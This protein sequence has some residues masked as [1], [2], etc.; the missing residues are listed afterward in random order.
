MTRINH[1]IS[2]IVTQTALGRAGKD[3]SNSLERLS[4][5]LRINR[6]ADDAAGLSVSE[7]LRTQVRGT[8][9]AMRNAADGNSLLRVAEGALNEVSEMTQRMRELAIQSD[10]D[11]LTSR[12]R[13]YLDQEFSQLKAEIT[14]ISKS[15]QFN[16]LT[17]LDGGPNS[18]GTTTGASILHIGAN[19][20]AGVDRLGITLDAV[21][22]TG[23]GL[24]SVGIAGGTPQ[25]AHANIN[26]AI[27]AL[28][29]AMR[30]V[31]NVRSKIG[32]M[33]N[34]LDHATAN[35]QIQEVNMQSAESTIR[36]TDFAYETT[37]FTRNQIL[38]QSATSMLSQANQIPRGALSLLGGG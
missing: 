31:N 34:R 28:D 5:G 9:A 27:S 24:Y 7:Q 14:R 37:Q 25:I 1:N 30:S 29:L 6:A 23:L 38:S 35:L 2:A 33:M 13:T 12:E 18:F 3:L 20:K 4:T 8:R 10:N 22:L 11:T 15:T 19:N 21:T 26:A 32:S 17:L 36:D 16:G